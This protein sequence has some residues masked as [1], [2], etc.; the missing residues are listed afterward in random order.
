MGERKRER[1]IG[2][3]RDFFNLLKLVRKNHPMHRERWRERKRE[4]EGGKRKK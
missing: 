4:K 2:R 3:R 1:K